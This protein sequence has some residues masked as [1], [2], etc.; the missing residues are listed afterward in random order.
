M[1]GKPKVLDRVAG[2]P[3]S[4]GI[5]EVPGWGMQLPIDR[6][7]SEM[8]GLG[9]KATEMG[10]LGWLP[11]E[12]AAVKAILATH[13]MATIGGFVALALHTPDARAASR[14][15]AQAVAATMAAA[16]AGFFIT[17][18]VSDPDDWQRPTISDVE[19]EQILVGLDE[20]E[21]ICADA[22]IRQVLHPHV[23]TFVE[24]AEEFERFLAGSTVDFCLDTGHLYLGGAD[25]AA[26]ATNHFD[27]IGLVHVKDV[28][29]DVAARFRSGELTLMEAVQH[30]LFPPAGEGD[31]PIAEIVRILERA[32]YGGWYVL[33]QD[34]AITS[35]EPAPGDG[36]VRD[37]ATSVAY[38]RKLASTL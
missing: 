20:I 27:R 5:C 33:E 9:L 31:V 11:E 4:W 38:L 12:P 22:G 23:N 8:S 7:L 16:G 14:V 30:G 1:R 10:A 37:V 32:G 15:H 25:P 34:V 2:A 28:R 6:V 29:A 17:A 36:P 3:I 21:Q 26:I 24:T 13:Q 35:G 19:W 18:V